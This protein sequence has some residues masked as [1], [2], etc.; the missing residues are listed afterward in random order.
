ME[1]LGAD[2]PVPSHRTSHFLHVRP[3]F[4]AE[5]RH[6]VDERDLHREE[7]VGGVFDHFRGLE[8]RLDVR[9]FIQGERP[10]DFLH[11]VP[12]L[13]LVSADYHAVRVRKVLHRRAFTEKLG[14]GDDVESMSCPAPGKFFRDP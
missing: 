2:S 5:V 10:V 4:L 7:R 8:A 12:R 1:E 3:D 14:V 13:G 9:R 11:C 6:L